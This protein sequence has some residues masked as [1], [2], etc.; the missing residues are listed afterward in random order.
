LPAIDT[1]IGT[2]LPCRKGR[3]LSSH[4]SI[5]GFCS[6][7]ALSIPDGVSNMRGVGSPSRGSSVTD[8]TTIAPSSAMSKNRS[9]SAPLAKH[10]DAVVIGF[11]NRRFPAMGTLRS[12]P[13]SATAC[14]STSAT[15]TRRT[16]LSPVTGHLPV[17]SVG[18]AGHRIDW[19]P[20]GRV[21]GDPVAR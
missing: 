18:G 16:S 10:P 6:P 15:V 17:A 12:T 14:S 7:I 1:M 11:A 8:F 19:D 5:P 13:D 9:I 2:F 21:P 3:S 4:P 20:A